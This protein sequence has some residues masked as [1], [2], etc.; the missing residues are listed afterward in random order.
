MRLGLANGSLVNRLY[1]LCLLKGRF[2][3]TFRGFFLP[4]NEP[5]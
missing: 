3:D 1:L 2:Y 4:E 5:L